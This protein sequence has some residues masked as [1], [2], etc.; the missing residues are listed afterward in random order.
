MATFVILGDTH[1]PF[2]DDD[3][4]DKAIDFIGEMEPDYVIQIGD[5]YDLYTVSKFQKNPNFIT[6]EKEMDEGRKAAERMW[7]RIKSASPRSKRIQLFGNHDLR[8]VK[9]VQ[10][11]ASGALHLAKKY[12]KEMMTFP[13]VETVSDEVEIA[14]IMFQHGHR[15]HGE[16][17]KYNQ[18]STVVGHLHKPGIVYLCN[19]NGPYWELNVGWLGDYRHEVFSYAAQKKMHGMLVGI[20]VIDELGPRFVAL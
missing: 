20:G 4:I 9:Y 15:K 17:A 13:G 19:R 1:F 2:A 6:P 10:E 7:S 11:S 18:Q 3:A 16:H 8:L 14:G 5:L 12:L